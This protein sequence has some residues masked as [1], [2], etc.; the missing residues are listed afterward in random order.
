MKEDGKPAP[1]L[2]L[3]TIRFYRKDGS[4]GGVELPVTAK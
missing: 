2:E 4:K 1:T 3:L